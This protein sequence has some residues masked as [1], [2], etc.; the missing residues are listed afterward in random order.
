MST[1][2]RPTDPYAAPAI[3][4][5]SAPSDRWLLPVYAATIFASAF[6][7]FQVQPIISKAILPWFGG[8]PAVWTTAMLFFQTLLFAGYAY[9]HFSREVL[10]PAVARGLHV[11]LLVLAAIAACW[12]I[13]PSSTLK[14]PDSNDPSGRILLLL[15]MTVALPYFV[16]SATGPLVQAWFSGSFPGRSP[17]RLYSLSNA[18]S[19]LALL[20]YPVLIEP[21]LKLSGQALILEI[22]FW[23]FAILCGYLALRSKVAGS[24]AAAES[25]AGD[26]AVAA[27]AV[28]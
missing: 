23:V 9:A 5:A 17:Y 11:L 4:T 28:P 12:S 13:L 16:L 21:A 22:G 27:L 26:G 14:P 18:G 20:S 6:L 19:L 24:S 10:P 15:A 7:L 8:S 3:S 25:V 1:T 2:V